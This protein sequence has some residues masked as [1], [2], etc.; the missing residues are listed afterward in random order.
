LKLGELGRNVRLP[1]Y[2]SK[3]QIFHTID[4]ILIATLLGRNQM[5]KMLKSFALA[6]ALALP[7]ASAASAAT[8]VDAAVGTKKLST[9]VAAVTAADLVG[10]LSSPGPF[11]VFA[12]TNVAF[13]L[14]PPGTVPTLLKPEN[15]GQLTKVL[16]AHV[17]SGKVTAGDLK[18]AIKAHGGKFRFHTVSGDALVA[19]TFGPAVIITDENGGR[20]VVT[21][22]DID[23]S[24]GVVHI[25]NKVLLPK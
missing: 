22:A 10:T 2:L 23:V 21:T 15:K 5:K 18:A 12:P 4:E 9:L 24:N 20:A 11:T 8:I 16:T 6:A 25:V 1:A 17:V 7:L 3:P 19:S 14:L 13:K